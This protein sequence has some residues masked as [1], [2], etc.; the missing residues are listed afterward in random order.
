MKE[1]KKPSHK[2]VIA[3]DKK[4]GATTLAI[5]DDFGLYELKPHGMIVGGTGRE[6]YS[7]EAADPLSAVMETHWTETRK[8]GKWDIRTE[9]YGRLK[10]T[11]T[12]WIVWGKIEAFEGKKRIFVKEFN[13]EIERRL[14]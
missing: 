1:L 10:A 9:T 11:K 8:R 3:T 7:I 12:H 4:T 5:V 14:Q 2:R 6:N 13:E